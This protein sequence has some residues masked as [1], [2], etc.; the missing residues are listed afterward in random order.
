MLLPIGRNQ[1][2]VSSL[3]N[4]CEVRTERTSERRQAFSGELF[5]VQTVG[6]DRI[7]QGCESEVPGSD[8]A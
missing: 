6:D 8:A 5:R 7:S 4:L 1:G 3:K 2:S